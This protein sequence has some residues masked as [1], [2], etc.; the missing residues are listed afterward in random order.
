[1]VLPDSLREQRKRDSLDSLR[2]LHSAKDR[3]SL[4]GCRLAW[5]GQ[6][7]YRLRSVLSVWSFERISNNGWKLA[8]LC[9]VPE[10]RTERH[11]RLH[12]CGLVHQRFTFLLEESLHFRGDLQR[13]DFFLSRKLRGGVLLLRTQPGR[14]DCHLAVTVIISGIWI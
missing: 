12:L 6:S 14:R 9:R 11:P 8:C 4:L 10:H 2:Q 5:S 3:E 13:N 1:M 7:S